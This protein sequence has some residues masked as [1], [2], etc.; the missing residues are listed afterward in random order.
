MYAKDGDP[1]GYILKPAEEIKLMLEDNMLNL[2]T[3]SSSRF[4]GQFADKV[5]T[6]EKSLNLVAECLEVWYNV[7]R[8][9]MYLESIFVGAEDIRMQ[10]PEEAKKFDAINKAFK[11]IMTATNAQPNVVKAC[12]TDQRLETLVSLGDRL[13]ACQKSLTDY[14]DTKRNAF[15]R[16]FFISDDE[17]LSVLGSSD[18]ASI[19]VHM[20]KLFDN[21]KTLEFS[22][23]KKNVV[24]MQSAEGERYDLIETGAAIEG[25]VETWMTTVE[26]QM[27]ISLRQITK[28]GVYAYAH[29]NRNDWLKSK[30]GMVGLVGSQIW[31]TW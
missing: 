3:M 15:P 4:V 31:W 25:P 5:R 21:V 2:Q 13:V 10:L 11:G 26:Q 7:Q 9:W 22:R 24:G 28:E 27:V 12:T 29:E 20:L 8:Q 1:R 6:W 17:L 23:N 30:L 19:Q 18:P 16:F 14:L